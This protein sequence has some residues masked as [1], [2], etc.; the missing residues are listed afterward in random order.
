MQFR[1]LSIGK[2]LRVEEVA[3]L[4]MSFDISPRFT[5][6]VELR[7]R[8]S[9]MTTNSMQAVL[10]Q[11]PNLRVLDLAVCASQAFAACTEPGEAFS[12][13]VRLRTLRL[14]VFPK[15]AP[16]A[17]ELDLIVPVISLSTITLPSL[18]VYAVDVTMMS[19]DSE[20]QWV[21]RC[22]SLFTSPRLRCVSLSS[23]EDVHLEHLKSFVSRHSCICEVD[24]RVP[25]N[26]DG[27]ILPQLYEMATHDGGLGGHRTQYSGLKGRLHRCSI[28][29]VDL[30][31]SLACSPFANLTGLALRFASDN[32]EDMCVEF[33]ALGGEFRLVQDLRLA[34]SAIPPFVYTLWKVRRLLNIDQRV[35]HLQ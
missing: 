17:E 20:L 21:A 27:T 22:L 23:N 14:A 32:T 33:L 18:L 2:H 6:L 13:L 7:C 5:G 4:G 11:N 8:G 31:T 25:S 15:P 9:V 12:G 10:V 28:K 26:M 24:L 19:A 34:A 3:D 16:A 30:P 1:S 29:S 35:I